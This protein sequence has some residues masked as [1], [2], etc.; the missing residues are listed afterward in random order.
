MNM[1][2]LQYE[3]NCDKDYNYIRLQPYGGKYNIPKNKIKPIIKKRL[4]TK[5]YLSLVE[6]FDKSVGQIL[7]WH[8]DIPL[9]KQLC[10]EDIKSFIIIVNKILMAHLLEVKESDLIAYILCKYPLH[11]S[12]QKFG[13][14]IYYP[15]I[16]VNIQDARKLYFQVVEE[17]ITKKL[18]HSWESFDRMCNLEYRDIIDSI[19]AHRTALMVY[20]CAKYND[21]PYCIRYKIDNK[22]IEKYDKDI[23]FNFDYFFDLFQY[24]QPEKTIYKIN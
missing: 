9:K 13:L 23:E 18:F 10:V 7:T 14:H 22:K 5:N 19:T 17:C 2:M 20:G 8:L 21:I 11:V 6:K 24:N 16:I 3:A 4:K 1:N 15:H 12:C